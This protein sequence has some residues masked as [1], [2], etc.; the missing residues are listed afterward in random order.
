MTWNPWFPDAPPR[1]LSPA[2]ACQ[3]DLADLLKALADLGAVRLAHH[4]V[5][6]KAAMGPCD[7]QEVL[8]RWNH[9]N[10]RLDDACAC[11]EVHAERL[12]R[13]LAKALPKPQHRLH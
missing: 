12:A 5:R 7:R 6:F 2:D 8:A 3:Q 11:V 9:A 13:S 10:D 4:E 1:V